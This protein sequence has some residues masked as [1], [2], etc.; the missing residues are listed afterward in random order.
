[1]EDLKEKAEG[2]LSDLRS[3]E[4]KAKHNFKMLEASLKDQIAADQKDMAEQKEDKSAA[5]EAK[6][7]AEGD[8]EMTVKALAKAT[9]ALAAT[10]ASCM[11]IAADHEASVTS[12]VVELKVIDEATGVLESMTSGAEGQT[13]SFLQTAVHHHAELKGS[14]VLSMVK[15]LAEFH[16]SAALAQLA[17]RIGAVARY[18]VANGADP[19][20]KVKGLIETL[21]AK[22]EKEADQDATEKAYC[23]EQMAKT[24]AK[25][26]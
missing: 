26:K 14:R 25:K 12:R 24:E 11:T 2:Q 23:D 8:L 13:Y 3:T 22:L 5:E 7:N 20:A 1:L 17:S 18:G 4:G 6:A 19:F 10:Q 16:H 9:E 21:I 15:H